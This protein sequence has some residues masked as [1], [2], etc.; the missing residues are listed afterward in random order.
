MN[1]KRDFAREN[2]FISYYGLKPKVYINYELNPDN[3]FKTFT[4]KF[5]YKDKEYILT[6]YYK[7]NTNLTDYCTLTGIEDRFNRFV[8]AELKL[9]SIMKDGN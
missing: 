2:L 4:L 7:D 8:D 3:T 6:E 5:T 1:D 9:V